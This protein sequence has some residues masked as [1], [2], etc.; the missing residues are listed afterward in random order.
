MGIVREKEE[1]KEPEKRLVEIQE[2]KE[3][4]NDEK[5][6]SN[7]MEN[8]QNDTVEEPVLRESRRERRKPDFY[9]EWANS[10][11]LVD[12]EPTTVNGDLSSSENLKW[13]IAM[14]REMQSIHDNDVWDLVELPNQRKAI[15]CKW[16]FK[17]KIGADGSVERYKAHLV[18]QGFSQ[19]HG[20]DYDETFSPVVRFESLRTVIALAV[21]NNLYLQ[22]M[23]FTSAFLNGNLEEEVYMK[24]P[25]GFVEKGKEN[26]V[27]KLKHSLYGLKQSPRS[28]T[29]N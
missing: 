8:E 2:S 6:V 14:E 12:E 10:V 25:E 28:C 5:E 9:R 4:S 23:D 16:V 29:P 20:L 26:L 11:R 1:L 21:Q 19:Q 7:E 15:G 24:Q 22:Q 13:K 18:A 17:R 27:C 3:D